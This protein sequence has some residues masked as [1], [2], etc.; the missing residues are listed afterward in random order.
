MK[1]RNILLLTFICICGGLFSQ[2]ALPKEKKERMEKELFADNVSYERQASLLDSLLVKYIDETEEEEDEFDNPASE[3]YEVWGTKGVNDGRVEL[4][5]VPDSILFDCSSYVNPLKKSQITSRF[6]MRRNRYHYGIDFRLNIGDTVVSAFD[7][8][9]RITKFDRRGYGSYV[10]VRHTNG[11][12]TVYGHLSKIKVTE[13]QSVLAGECIGLG[14]NTGR[15]TGSHLHFE[16]RFLGN[17]INPEKFFNFETKEPKQ[18][19]FLMVKN[20]AFDYIKEV[21]ALKARK[22]HKVRSGDTLSRIARRYG[23]SVNNICRLNGI[24]RNKTLRIGQQIRYN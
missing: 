21:N 16:T 17:P 7:G 23:T 4:K 15:S 13:G 19:E 11:L 8:K 14:G 24:S 6:G 20:D 18:A 10:V 3:Y 12:E 1:K 22:Y 5:N 9:V 2:Q